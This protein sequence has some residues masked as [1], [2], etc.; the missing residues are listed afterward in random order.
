MA[1]VSRSCRL[2]GFH[3]LD[4]RQTNQQQHQRQQQQQQQQQQQ[5]SS[6]SDLDR[7]N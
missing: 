4:F 6:R 3:R 5:R 1:I 7:A 2:A